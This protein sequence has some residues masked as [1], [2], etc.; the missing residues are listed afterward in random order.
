MIRENITKS[1]ENRDC[2]LK[3]TS[4]FFEAPKIKKLRK[5]AG[6][7]TFICIYLKL[8]LSTLSKNGIFEFEG[9]EK[10]LAEEIALKLDEEAINVEVVINFLFSQGM[11]EEIN[12]GKEF[13][14]NQV[15]YLIVNE[16]ESAERIED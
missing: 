16:S 14:L 13:L 11:L 6:G 4:N 2:E 15:P 5:F 12:E 3:L 7:D 9:I 8:M 10:T 1:C